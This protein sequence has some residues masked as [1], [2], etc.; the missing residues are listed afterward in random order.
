MGG[1]QGSPGLTGPPRAR[2]QPCRGASE[3]GR[4]L[5]WGHLPRARSAEE[6]PG[7]T[8]APIFSRAKGP[9]EGRR[10]TASSPGGWRERVSGGVPGPELGHAYAMLEFQSSPL[11]LILSQPALAPFPVPRPFAL[12]VSP[13]LGWG[14]LGMGGQREGRVWKNRWTALATGE[15]I[16]S[17][18]E[19]CVFLTGSPSP[20][21]FQQ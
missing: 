15:V 3:R 5:P 19:G 14:R 13:V 12:Y 21:S 17:S 2:P 7:V 9:R 20:F 1:L 11:P 16:P 18:P 8:E 4:G 10:I 6:G